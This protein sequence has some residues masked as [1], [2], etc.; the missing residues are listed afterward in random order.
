MMSLL[1]S[2]FKHIKFRFGKIP[3]ESYSKLQEYLMDDICSIFDEC[4]R[5]ENYI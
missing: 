5:D 4:G 1:F 3:V 2:I